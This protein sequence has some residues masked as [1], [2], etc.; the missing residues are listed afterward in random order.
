MRKEIEYIV[1]L[2][3][4]SH[5]TPI[6]NTSICDNKCRAQSAAVFSHYAIAFVFLSNL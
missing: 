3:T 2:Q 4:F 5:F 6:L 1:V